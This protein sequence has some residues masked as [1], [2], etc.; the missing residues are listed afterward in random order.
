M[1]N[2]SEPLVSIG[3]TTYNRTDLFKKVLDSIVRQSYKNLEIIVSKDFGSSNDTCLIIDEFQK[4][5]SRIKYYEQKNNIGAVCNMDFVL[6]KA[7]GDYFAWF[8]D[9]DLRDERWVEILLKKIHKTNDCIA[10]SKV[11]SVDMDGKFVRNYKPQQFSGSK[12]VRICKYFLKPEVSGKVLP[13]CGLFEINLLRKLKKLKRYNSKWYGIDYLFVLESL[14]YSNI[15]HDDSV[16][17]YKCFEKNKYPAQTSVNQIVNSFYRRM[18]YL[19]NTILIVNDYKIK[20]TLS[21]L[22]PIKI[23]TLGIEKLASYIYR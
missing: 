12:I 8:D 6:S 22:L 19:C 7:S 10:I 18:Q 21:L 11:V 15:I 20:I 3:V 1:R 17:M 9:D 14:Q 2:T 16:T 13:I 4:T 5:D 23:G